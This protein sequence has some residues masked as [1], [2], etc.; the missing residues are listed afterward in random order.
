MNR[1]ISGLGHIYR[2]LRSKLPREDFFASVAM[3]VKYK[4]YEI[5]YGSQN[6]RKIKIL[7]NRGSSWKIKSARAKVLRQAYLKFATEGAWCCLVH[8]L[9]ANRVS[10]SDLVRPFIYT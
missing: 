6:I 7:R 4:V 3:N 5:A 2:L 1:K 10:R 9:Y 8:L